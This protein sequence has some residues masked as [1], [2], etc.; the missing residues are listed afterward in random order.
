MNINIQKPRGF[1]IEGKIISQNFMG[2]FSRITVQTNAG[3]NLF[4][5]EPSE[6]DKYTN[7]QNVFINW[8]SENVQLVKI[9]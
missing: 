3:K 4:I 7:M 6:R 9:S 8:K 1:C 5:L 2:A